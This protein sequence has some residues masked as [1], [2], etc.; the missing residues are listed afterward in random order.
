MIPSP[1]FALTDAD[2]GSALWV[3]LKA[4]LE[5]RLAAERARNDGDLDQIQTANARGYLRCV[6]G[7]LALDDKPPNDG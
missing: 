7:L 3:R 5:K 1:D 4:N 2:R 6:R